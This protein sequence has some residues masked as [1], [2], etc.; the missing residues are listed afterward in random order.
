MKSKEEAEE[1]INLLKKRYNFKV[2]EF[3]DKESGHWFEEAF[4]FI[5][6]DSPK[7]IEKYRCYELVLCD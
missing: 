1:Y 5:V 3:N 6:V 4:K 7:V 2:F